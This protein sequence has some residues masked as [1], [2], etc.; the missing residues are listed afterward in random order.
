M[1]NQMYFWMIAK[2]A[3]RKKYDYSS[4]EKNVMNTNYLMCVRRNNLD[5]CFRRITR[6]QLSTANEDIQ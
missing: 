6:G 4:S 2:T 3:V 1:N 5:I